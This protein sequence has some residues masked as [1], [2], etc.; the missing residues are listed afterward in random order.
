MESVTG[1]GFDPFLNYLNGVVGGAVVNYYQP[2]SGHCLGGN[3]VESPDY[4][5][6]AVEHWHNYRDQVLFFGCHVL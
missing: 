3:G 4:Q 5:V 1:M 6:C 2:E